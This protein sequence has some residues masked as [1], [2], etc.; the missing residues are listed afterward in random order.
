[1]ST[2]VETATGTVEQTVADLDIG[3]LSEPFRSQFGWH[4]VQLLDR[5]VYDNTEEIKQRNCDNRIRNS[6]MEEETQL[7]T[8]RLRDEAYVDLRM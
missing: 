5:R 4:I 1:M 8:R 7:W 3:E 2:S 6:K